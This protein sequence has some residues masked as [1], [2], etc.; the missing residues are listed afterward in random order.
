M[1]N[2][3]STVVAAGNAMTGAQARAAWQGASHHWLEGNSG[4]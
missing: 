2:M 4:T 3:V 1:V